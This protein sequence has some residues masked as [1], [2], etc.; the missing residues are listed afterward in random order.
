MLD[1]TD[2]KK[3]LGVIINDK[4]KCHAHAAAA[5]KGQTKS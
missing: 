5:K 4:L 2:R 3:E 1:E